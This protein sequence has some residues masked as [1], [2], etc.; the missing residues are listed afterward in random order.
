MQLLSRKMPGLTLQCK[1]SL[2]RATPATHLGVGL[3]SAAVPPPL[4]SHQRRQRQGQSR[5]L[6]VY[7]ANKDE[8]GDVTEI[9]RKYSSSSNG[10]GA[11]LPARGR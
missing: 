9:L 5:Q 6:T 11:G 8:L 2:H 3:R 10:N 4:C 7:A 1:L